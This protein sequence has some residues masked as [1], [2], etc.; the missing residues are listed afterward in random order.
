[1]KL[2]DIKVN[3]YELFE[4]G[5]YIEF[6]PLNYDIQQYIMNGNTYQLINDS[7]DETIK[8]YKPIVRAEL[9]SL[10]PENIKSDY[11][12][13]QYKITDSIEVPSEINYDIYGF[14]KKKTIVSGELISVEYYRNYN[15]S[16]GVYS[17]LIVKETKTY[18]RDTLNIIISR[19]TKIEWYLN[20]ESVGF[21]KVVVKYY[22]PDE[23]I[24]EGVERRKIMIS[25]A[26]NTLLTE[27]RKTYDDLTSQQYAYDLLISLSVEIKYF[28]DGYTQPIIDG[29]NNSTKPYLT[30][31][32]KRLIVS[33]LTF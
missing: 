17:D 33:D 6:V 3:R 28:E 29:I 21:T 23:A 22:S 12:N 32:L 19:R 1:M 4:D 11:I 31:E 2:F 8:Y 30:T 20:D 5:L 9:Y 18:E 14:I 15:S 16:T 24:T 10:L 25:F 26:K 13:V 7:I 27:L